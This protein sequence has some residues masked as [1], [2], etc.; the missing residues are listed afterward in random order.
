[1][2]HVCR[3]CEISFESDAPARRACS[4]ACCIALAQ[5]ARR[6]AGTNSIRVKLKCVVCGTS[7][8]TTPYWV[9]RGRVCC[10][11]RCGNEHANNGS[12]ATVHPATLGK[13]C[14]F[15]GR[16]YVVAWKHRASKYCSRRCSRDGI[17]S[18]NTGLTIDTDER[19]AHV[20][21]C[22]K[23]TQ[24]RRFVEGKAYQPG[25]GCWH[26]SS[27]LVGNRVWL[28]S[29]YEIAFAVVLDADDDVLSY[30]YEGVEIPYVAEDG[31][32]RCYYPDF[33]VTRLEKIDLVEVKPFSLLEK[34]GNPTKL[35]A[36]APYCQERGWNL[37]V[38]TERDLPLLSLIGHH[39]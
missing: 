32:S 16:S 13:L 20:S 10:G 30:R 36:A 18:W 35:A 22:S 2:E 8:E 3:N 28:R 26:T 31:R 29:S 25:R 12:N 33:L 9:S 4:R 11:I 15:C 21:E 6:E 1:M 5:R 7:F 37:V 24:H 34:R 38:V 39:V 23:R 19:L 14:E 17:V 27:K